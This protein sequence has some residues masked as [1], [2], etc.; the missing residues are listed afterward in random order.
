M[1]RPWR[2][3]AAVVV[4]GCG[5]DVRLG[6][7]FDARVDSAPDASGNPFI[8]AAYSLAFLDP[9]TIDCQGTLAGMDAQFTGITRASLSLVD[10]NVDLATPTATTLTLAG[11]PITTGWSTASVEL[12]P[13]DVSLPPNVWASI[14]TTDVGPGPASTRRDVQLLG[15]DVTTASASAGIQGEVGIGYDTLDLNGTCFVTFGAL[16]QKL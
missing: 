13:D 3:V 16:L 4:A 10:G 12:A 2:I 6:V 15:V 5:H 1:T 11:P 8:P 7:A 9:P 14:I